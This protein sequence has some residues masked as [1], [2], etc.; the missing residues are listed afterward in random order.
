MKKLLFPLFLLGIFTFALQSC[1]D[2]DEATTDDDITTDDD[3][4]GS[5]YGN[6]TGVFSTNG[7]EATI[8]IPGIGGLDGEVLDDTP[9]SLSAAQVAG[10]PDSINVD[11]TLQV[12]VSGSAVPVPVELNVGYDAA[13]QTFTR[14][15]TDISLSVLGGAVNIEVLLVELQGDFNG[16]DVSGT[17]ELD[18]PSDA[19]PGT[20]N[21]DA[22]FFFSGTKQ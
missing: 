20:N 14:T 12:T 13:A 18:D 22:I 6:Y 7:E 9:F 3:V 11:I 17:I 19:E 4:Q 16:D 10:S 5:V 8:L 1:G 2:D 21:I 15:N